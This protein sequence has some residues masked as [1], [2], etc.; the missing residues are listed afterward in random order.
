MYRAAFSVRPGGMPADCVSFF[1]W[2]FYPEVSVSKVNQTMMSPLL[3]PVILRLPGSHLHS[4]G[5]NE[6][7]MTPQALAS[8]MRCR[9]RSIDNWCR[10]HHNTVWY[11]YELC[12]TVIQNL[13]HFAL[14]HQLKMYKL[15]NKQNAIWC[16]YPVL[17][18]IKE[19]NQGNTTHWF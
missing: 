18:F 16:Y 14:F 9:V 6:S 15:K 4:H 5:I 10:I 17:G 8:W 13:K 3:C 12:S 11:M 19:I 2:T 7:I 1:I